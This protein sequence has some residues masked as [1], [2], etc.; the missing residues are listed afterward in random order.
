MR[1]EVVEHLQSHPLQVPAGEA[2]TLEAAQKL[3]EEDYQVRWEAFHN[4]RNS[5]HAQ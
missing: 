4:A 3:A 5:M 2:L 1:M